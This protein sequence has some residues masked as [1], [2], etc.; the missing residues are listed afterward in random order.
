MRFRSTRGGQDSDLAGAILELAEREE[1]DLI[2]MVTHANSR[3]LTL[4]EG[5]VTERVLTRT[6]RPLLVVHA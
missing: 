6:H 3:L 5:S 2:A 1:V 4:L